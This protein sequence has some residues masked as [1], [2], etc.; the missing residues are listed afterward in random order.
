[1]NISTIFVDLLFDNV[2]KDEYIDTNGMKIETH[3]LADGRLHRNHGPAKV[4]YDKFG[5]M[6]LEEWYQYG[7]LHRDNDQPAVVEYN[8]KTYE[9]IR[10][11]WY[12]YGQ[13]D[14]HGLYKDMNKGLKPALMQANDEDKHF[15][16]KIEI[17]ENKEHH[18][19]CTDSLNK[20]RDND[21]VHRNI[22]D[23]KERWSRGI[24]NGMTSSNGVPDD[25]ERCI[26]D[27]R[28]SEYKTEYDAENHKIVYT[29]LKHCFTGSKYWYDLQG[30]FHRKNGPAVEYHMFKKDYMWY[31]EG[32][33]FETIRE[34][35]KKS[36]SNV[37]A[38]GWNLC[39]YLFIRQIMKSWPW[40]VFWK[41]YWWCDK[42]KIKLHNKKRQWISFFLLIC[43]F[44]VI[45]ATII[46]PM[47]ILPISKFV[48]NIISNLLV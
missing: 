27:G 13:K 21:I 9:P 32:E 47:A 28:I 37:I 23:I 38:T 6:L 33:K 8:S 4:K 1:M 11:I 20:L 25:I 43:L 16:Y 35:L 15:V 24:R 19:T 7:K 22:D 5:H 46:W 42:Q 31:W 34:Y 10:M 12:Q 39:K 30:R 18:I 3:V 41:I 14:R 2:T 44:L 45:V 29:Y 40:F 36:K 48:W 17:D 26:R